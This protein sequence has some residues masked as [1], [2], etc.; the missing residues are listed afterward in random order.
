MPQI[1]TTL[2]TYRNTRRPETR[3]IGQ[4]AERFIKQVLF[5]L[6]LAGVGRTDIALDGE[7]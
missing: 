4:M 7:Q 6:A 2:T 3:G 5:G 1:N